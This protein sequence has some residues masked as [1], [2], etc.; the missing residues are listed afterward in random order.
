M[1]IQ[2]TKKSLSIEVVLLT[3]RGRW[4]WIILVVWI[5]H[6]LYFYFVTKPRKKTMAYV[7]LQLKLS[8]PPIWAS[9]F[10]AGPP[11]PPLSGRSLLMTP[12][13]I[14]LLEYI[15]LKSEAVLGNIDIFMV[16][17]TKIDMS[18]PTSQ[19]VIQGFAA[20]FRLDRTNTGGW[21]LVYIRDGIPS[22]L[23]NISYVSSDTECLVIEINLRKTKWLL[24]CSYNPHKT[25]FQ[26]ICQII[27]RNSSRYD[28][29]FYIGDFNSET[30]ET[31][32][33][34][35]CDLYKLKNLVRKPT[36]F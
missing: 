4:E 11:F 14:I 36:C 1:T 31:A 17:E 12:S 5:A 24:I 26:I 13:R 32:L 16:S 9:T 3:V 34:N 15:R 20:P 19:F 10:L 7:R 23:L 30:S 18:F 28:K 22:K 6:L 2:N 33:R 8:L 29:Y 27:D 25:I 21:I 35:F